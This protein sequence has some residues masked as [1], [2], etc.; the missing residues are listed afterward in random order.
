MAIISCPECG[1]KISDKAE[2]CV[3]CGAEVNV[4]FSVADLSRLNTANEEESEPVAPKSDIDYSQRFLDETPQIKKFLGKMSKAETIYKKIRYIIW[5]IWEIPFAI[6][7]IKFNKDGD[8]FMG[9]ALPFMFALMALAAVLILNAWFEYYPERKY[10]N[11]CIR[12]LQEGGYDVADYI[13][14]E[15]NAYMKLGDMDALTSL[16]NFTSG[17]YY[18]HHPEDRKRSRNHIIIRSAIGGLAM[19]F[20][21]FVIPFVAAGAIMDMVAVSTMVTCIVILAA[22]MVVYFVTYIVLIGAD[23][24]RV[25]SV[26]KD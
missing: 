2:K 17:W 25:R 10:I 5:L 8:S 21:V 24:K 26:Y 7:I 23:Y 3:H 11:A 1:Q 18:L 6:M 22:L 9:F 4:K 19:L 12:W 13:N 14:N 20:M 15:Y 16:L